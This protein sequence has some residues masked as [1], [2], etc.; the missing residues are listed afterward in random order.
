MFFRLWVVEIVN[1][2]FIFQLATA[3]LLLEMTNL[4]ASDD[5]FP[6]EKRR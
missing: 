4:L 5:P 3:S 2:S 1:G 6:T